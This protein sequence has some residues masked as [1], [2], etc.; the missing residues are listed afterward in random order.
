MRP[1]KQRLLQRQRR[2]QR[3][4]TMMG[5]QQRRQQTMQGRG[6]LQQAIIGVRIYAYIQKGVGSHMHM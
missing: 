3:R 4:Q 6:R 5:L 1:S 2:Q